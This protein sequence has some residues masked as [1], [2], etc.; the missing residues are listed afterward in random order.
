[1]RRAQAGLVGLAL[2]LLGLHPAAF[3]QDPA[4][5]Q[6]PAYL[7]T[8]ARIQDLGEAAEQA[9]AWRE[10]LANQPGN[11]CADQ[12]RR[13]LEAL[14]AS[15]RLN[16]E[17]E[18][19]ERWQ[20][21][22]RG[23]VVEPNR[24]ELPLHTVFPDA[25]P[26]DRIRVLSEVIWLGTGFKS[27]QGVE[28]IQLKVERDA[29]WTLVL[30]SEV[31]LISHLAVDL[32]L[33]LVFG[34]LRDSGFEAALGNI[35]LGLRGIWG[36]RVGQAGHPWAISGGVIWGSG[37]SVWMGADSRVLLDSAAVGGAHF[38]H[39][40]RYDSPD[41]AL[42]ASS[43]IGLGVHALGLGL[44]YHVYAGGEH[45]E[46]ILRF[47]LAWD[48]RLTDRLDVGLELNGGVGDGE[49]VVGAVE[50]ELMFFVFASPGL[51]LRFGWLTAAF[52]LRVPLG[53]AWDWTRLITS[54][55]LGARL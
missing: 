34:Q 12:V 19:R 29:L 31:A 53:D 43:Q 2:G 6:D 30:R 9:R 36:Q 45:V 3:G 10:F 1:M 44:A 8:E 18:K 54:I 40:F 28:N 48:W 26:V 15:D 55:E 24:D 33:P 27:D 23:G 49:P 13:K 37:S 20:Q 17:I 11:P 35:A 50:N 42:R 41:Y 32:D 14:Q 5:C 16:Q 39:L 4:G 7:Q 52:S 25:V 22:A 47:D 46:K 38:R 51:R 21:E